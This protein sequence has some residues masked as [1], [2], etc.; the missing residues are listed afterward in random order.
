MKKILIALCILSLSCTKHNTIDD[1]T[2]AEVIYVDVNDS[3]FSTDISPFLEDDMDVIALE[4]NDSCLVSKILK[5]EFYKENI[6][7]SDRTTQKIYR[8]DHRGKFMNNVGKIGSGPEEY[9]SLG[10][11]N[12]IDDLIYVQD[13]SLGKILIYSFD[14]K[15][16][17]VLNTATLIH[18]Y[19]FVNVDGKLYFITNYRRTDLGFYNIYEMN[20]SSGE[21]K[22]FLPYN[23]SIET[24]QQRWGLRRYMSKCDDSALSVF[25][26]NDLIYSITNNGISP[27][28][29]IE[30][31]ERKIPE[32]EI[33]KGGM[34]AMETAL[35]KD[36]ILGV[37]KIYDSENYLFFSFSD[38][39]K[40]RDVVYD[41]TNKK[42]YLSEWLF[43]NNLGNLYGTDYFTSNNEFAIIQDAY[44]YKDLWERQYSEFK[45]KN[46][47]DKERMLNIYNSII[48]DDNPVLFRFKFKN[49]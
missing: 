31:S 47:K 32:E 35:S 11:F 41:K 45:F 15:F 22:G 9:A 16:I 19:E 37:D 3:K 48:E 7:I 36:Y 2:T 5:V 24:E 23:E 43:V 12:I 30:F 44:L 38:G 20:L 42:S 39:S 18:F 1:S 27:K 49:N 4:T 14:N 29:K 33:K 6:F 17:K 21:I 8:F 26:N 10:D 46:E 40:G 13:E 25:S 34:H 28:Y